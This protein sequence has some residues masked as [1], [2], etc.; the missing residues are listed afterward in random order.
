MNRV[1]PKPGPSE[2][3]SHGELLSYY[4]IMIM[5]IILV[6][7][8]VVILFITIVMFMALTMWSLVLFISIMLP[9]KGIILG[10]TA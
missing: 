9:F 8:M 3:Y 10:Y 2:G 7:T 5:I 1:S 6:V 4:S